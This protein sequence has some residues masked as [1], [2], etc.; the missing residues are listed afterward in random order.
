M[1]EAFIKEPF[2]IVVLV[3][4]FMFFIYQ[5]TKIVILGRESSL[6]SIIF[7]T[8]DEETKER[9]E[10]NHSLNDYF[11]NLNNYTN[12]YYTIRNTKESYDESVTGCEDLVNV[13]SDHC[14]STCIKD[15][16]DEFK[17]F[18]TSLFLKSYA[19]DTSFQYSSYNPLYLINLGEFK[20]KLSPFIM[21]YRLFLRVSSNTYPKDN[22]N[23][24]CI[25]IYLGNHNVITFTAFSPDK[26]KRERLD[27][28]IKDFIYEAGELYKYFCFSKKEK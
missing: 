4:I 26:K 20:E 7:G 25:I 2:L 21:S 22:L 15:V 27:I 5:I 10:S 12:R 6:S 18:V 28:E 23:D 14:I 8:H 3:F 9:K 24:S 11:Q 16:P 1:T 13:D 19:K 17:H